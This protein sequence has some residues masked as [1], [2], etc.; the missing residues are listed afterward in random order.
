MLG[1]YTDYSFVVIEYDDDPR[2]MLKE[3]ASYEEA[4][5]YYGEK[6][7]IVQPQ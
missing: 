3:F 5:E 2:P 4:C 6:I 1:Y 7:D